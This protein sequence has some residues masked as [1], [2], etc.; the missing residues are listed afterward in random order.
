VSFSLPPVKARD[1]RSPPDR[2]RYL[3]L[4]AIMLGSIMGPIDLS[5]GN[6][7]LPT[8]AQSFGVGISTAQ[9]VPMVYLLTISSLLLFYGRLG[10]IL[11]AT[12]RCTWPA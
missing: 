12:K 5:I 2:Q 9:W 4:A 8:V 11:G 1:I 6:V 10:D 7:V 3:V